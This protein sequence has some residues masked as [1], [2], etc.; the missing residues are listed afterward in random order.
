MGQELLPMTSGHGEGKKQT[1][2]VN[3][4]NTG[5]DLF[6]NEDRSYLLQLKSLT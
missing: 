2:V 5:R 4:L 6:I 1:V 3:L